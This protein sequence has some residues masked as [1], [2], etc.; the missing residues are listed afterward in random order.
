MR[1]ASRL[2]WN[3]DRALARYDQG[4]I[5][6]RPG[7]AYPTPQ[8]TEGCVRRDQLL[9]VTLMDCMLAA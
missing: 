9:I 2:P 7:Q 5:C 8:T 3:R 4:P 1:H 6:R